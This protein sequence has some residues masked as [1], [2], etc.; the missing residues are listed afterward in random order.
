MTKRILGLLLFFLYL[1]PSIGISGSLH[2]CGGEVAAIVII[3]TDEHPC[4]CGPDEPMDGSCCQDKAF[5]LKIK[6]SHKNVNPQSFLSTSQSDFTILESNYFLINRVVTI[7]SD[8]EKY[9]IEEVEPP[10]DK[11]FILFESYLI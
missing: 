1:I 5:S 6:D 2:Y 10:D 7:S 4:A 9:I 3:P 11:L 8:S